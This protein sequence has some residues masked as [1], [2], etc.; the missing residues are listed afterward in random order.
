[1]WLEMMIHAFA[2][3]DAGEGAD[4]GCDD[5]GANNCSRIDTSVLA[6]VG[7]D[8]DGNQLQG[9]N[10]ENQEGAHFIAGNALLLRRQSAVTAFLF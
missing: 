5:G 9:R 10:I 4:G 6:S 8:V 7:N 3:N 2:V 1:M